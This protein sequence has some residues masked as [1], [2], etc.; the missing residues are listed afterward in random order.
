MREQHPEYAEQVLTILTEP[1]RSNFLHRIAY[2]HKPGTH[3]R[4]PRPS[5]LFPAI[6]TALDDRFI[7]EGHDKNITLCRLVAAIPSADQRDFYERYLTNPARAI[8]WSRLPRWKR[9]IMAGDDQDKLIWGLFTMTRL[10]L[11]GHVNGFPA[12]VPGLGRSLVQEIGFWEGIKD[13]RRAC[14]VLS[15]YGAMLAH[16]EDVGD[17]VT[18]PWKEKPPVKG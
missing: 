1:E 7:R 6:N 11:N 10:R 2:T 18:P 15:M 17:V 16:G 3:W 5:E 9:P 13:H 4:F 12:T 14:Q 8:T